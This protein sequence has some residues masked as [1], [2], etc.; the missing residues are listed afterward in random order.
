MEITKR[1]IWVSLGIILVMLGIAIGLTFMV[2]DLSQERDE[3]YHKALKIE[4]QEEVSH[5]Y[6]SGAGLSFIQIQLDSNDSVT[7]PNLIGEYLYIHENVEKYTEHTRTVTDDEGNSHTETYW[8]WDYYSSDTKMVDSVLFNEIEIPSDRLNFPSQSLQLTEETCKAERYNSSYV[9]EGGGWFNGP[10][11]RKSYSVVEA[12]GT[13]STL[14]FFD[15]GEIQPYGQ[16]NFGLSLQSVEDLY[17]S[18]TGK[19]LL[20]LILVWLGWLF[21]TVGLVVGFYY[22]DNHWLNSD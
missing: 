13:Y 20:W 19:T 11:L 2:I 21:V 9:N 18:Y 14:V 4:S 16:K 1:E 3:V 6:R 5:A 12:G 10:R 7:H 8:T 17:K 15:S 22:L